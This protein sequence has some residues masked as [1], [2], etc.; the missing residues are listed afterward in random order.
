MQ[1]IGILSSA[2]AVFR[3]GEQ[4]AA[5]DCGLKGAGY[6]EGENVTIE[7]YRWANDDYGRLPALATELARLPVAVI[8]AAGGQ[9]SALAAQN[10]T[11]DI[12]IVFTTVADPVSNGLVASLDSPGGNATGTAGLTSELDPAPARTNPHGR[13]HRRARRS[14]TSGTGSPIVCSRKGGTRDEA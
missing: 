14:E 13:S 7:E 1:V 2:S 8:V 12:P 4:F 9:V 3:D 11:K 10:A 6:T 5:F